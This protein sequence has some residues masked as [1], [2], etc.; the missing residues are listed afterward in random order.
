MWKTI[1]HPETK[2]DLHLLGYAEGRR[3]LKIIEQR[4]IHGEPD[5]IGKALSGD[6]AGYRRIRFSNTRIIYR[7]HKKEIEIFI[8]AIG[9]RRDDFVYDIAKKRNN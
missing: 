6:L 7:I 1:Y 9:M 3:I 8:I 5:K 4:I 2:H